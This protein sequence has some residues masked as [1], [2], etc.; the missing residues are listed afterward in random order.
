MKQLLKIKKMKKL[1]LAPIL[2]IILSFAACSSDD[3][4][5]STEEP[6]VLDPITIDLKG[7]DDMKFSAA[8]FQVAAKQEINLTLKNSGKLPKE[9]MGHNFI[10]LTPGTD[11]SEFATAALSAKNEDYIPASYADSIVAHTKL[12]G[13][14]ESDTIQFQIDEPGVYE[15]ICS[16][17][18]HWGTMNGTITVE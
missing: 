2:V 13:P 15:F 4:K 16:F 1:F 11:K 7:E 14:G 10:V 9:A 5:D 3:K 6:V 17:P 8:D 12:L 18:G